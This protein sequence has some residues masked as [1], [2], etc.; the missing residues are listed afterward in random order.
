MKNNRIIY[1]NEDDCLVCGY[2]P[3]ADRASMR[4]MID[5]IPLA[6]EVC[7]KCHKAWWQNCIVPL[8]PKPPTR[9]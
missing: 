3:E 1:G 5:S 2:W 6:D 8:L 9:H 7:E 4:A